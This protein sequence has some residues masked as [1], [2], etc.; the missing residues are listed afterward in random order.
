MAADL[1]TYQSLR[2]HLD[3]LL[4]FLGEDSNNLNLLADTA[5]AAL[6]A[7]QFR[8]CNEL[9]ER[10][11]TIQPLTPSLVNVRGLSA[12]AE[13]RFEAARADF[14][15]LAKHDASPVLEYNLSY[16][17]AM[18]GSFEP[19]ANMQPTCL[20]EVPGAA[21]LQL[22][23]LHHF[24]RF[25]EAVRMGAQ[26]AEQD[27]PPPGFAG[28][29]AALLFDLGD[30]TNARRLAARS[31]ES[32]DSLVIMGLAELE[33]GN[34]LRAAEL[35]EQA[36]DSNPLEARAMLGRGLCLLT[37][38]RYQDAATAL[39]E[40]AER[41]ARHA[42]SWLA[43]G[44]AWLFDGNPNAAIDRFQRATALDR[45]FAEAHGSLAVA[46]WLGGRHDDARRN[47]EVALRLDPS[48]MSGALAKS[49]EL[50]AENKIDSANALKEVVL[51]RPLG[52]TGRTLAQS[53]T[54]FGLKRPHNRA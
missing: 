27:A 17:S 52:S 48:S 25:D 40:A 4:S 10:Y 28:A 20:D 53:L 51:N 46:L 18:C 29:Y 5:T 12:M 43:A 47:A 6:E 26:L 8:L 21:L 9:L 42:G 3:R 7:G 13:G 34:I 50:E 23:A 31:P 49:L 2:A 30:L 54:A 22:R 38:E 37:Q 39:D 44:W 15:A 32:A 45:G 33:S 11:A 24:G 41:L 14:Q 16:A 36:A 35:L 19:A 1:Q